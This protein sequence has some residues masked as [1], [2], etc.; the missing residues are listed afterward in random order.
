VAVFHFQ[1]SLSVSF[2]GIQN[3]FLIN[4]HRPTA[5]DYVCG[6]YH[7]ELLLP[8][9]SHPGQNRAEHIVKFACSASRLPSALGLVN[10][11]PIR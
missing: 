9:L 8:R 6:H 7:G 11:Q 2:E 5:A 3:A 1:Q 10:K 4:F